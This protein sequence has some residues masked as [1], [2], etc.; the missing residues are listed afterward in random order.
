MTNDN[1]SDLIEIAK[2]NGAKVIETRC[3]FYR[4]EDDCPCETAGTGDCTANEPHA[5]RI[6]VEQLQA[7]IDAVN[8]QTNNPNSIEEVSTALPVGWVWINQPDG[9]TVF[10][11]HEYPRP[12]SAKPVY[13]APPQANDALEK[14]AKICDEIGKEHNDPFQSVRCAN[15]IRALKDK[16]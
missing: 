2:A 12:S 9:K 1:T 6:T 11:T 5:I 16:G 4:S 13:L 3:K 8:A 15:A 10:S 7:T 14:A